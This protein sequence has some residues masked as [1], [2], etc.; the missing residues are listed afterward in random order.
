MRGWIKL[1][2][3]LVYLASFHAYYRERIEALGIGL[4]L[5]LYLGVFALLAL[6][7]LLTAFTRPGW[8]RWALALAFTISAIFLDAYNRITD[9]YLTYSAFV[10]MVYA[11]AFVQEALQQYH[12]A[13]TLAAARALLLLFG[14]GLRPGPTP[15]LPRLLPPVA[16]VLGLLVLIAILFVRA[17]E[18]ARGLPVMYTP[19]AYL[20]LFGYETLHD[21]VGPRQPVSLAQSGP[22]MARDIV[23]LIDESISGNYLDLNTPAG[24]TSHLAQAQPG[25]SIVNFG[26]AASIANCSADTNVT[27]RYGG[28]R[29]DYLRINSTQ[30][31]IWQY[32][33]RAGLGTVYIDGQRT[34]G[35]LQNLMTETEKRDIDQFI[36]FDD[37]PVVQ[38]DMAALE[39]LVALLKDGKSQ[40][41]VV[42]KVGAHFPVHDKYPDDFLKY[43]PAL[44]RGRYVDIADTGTRDGFDGRAQDW[45]LYRNAYQNTVLWNVGEFFRRLF[46]EGDLSQAVVLYTSDHGQDLHERGNPGLNTH[47]D[48]DPVPEE[49]LVPLVVIQGEGLRT[50]DWQAHLPANRNASSHYN[51]F[52]TLLKLMGYDGTAVS[53]L[54]GRSLDMPTDDPFTFNVRFNARLGAKPDFRHIDLGQVVTPASVLAGQP[55]PVGK[56][57]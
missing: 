9:A 23:L 48:S 37:T 19:L 42:N 16:P 24:V 52:P 49:G 20:S 4:P 3:L 50:L 38:R 28:T 56:A 8:L 18:G 33:K 22:A 57:D 10:S 39:R 17:G 45:V 46:A 7:L 55:M 35:N 1:L 53:A 5:V 51:L 27:L 40:L 26:Y 15:W 54:Y 2:L 43:Q 34:G 32:A 14:L 36:Q 12:Y 25:V 47:C 21:H 31:S 11:G 44:P 6:A 29:G 30:P 41:I 13:I